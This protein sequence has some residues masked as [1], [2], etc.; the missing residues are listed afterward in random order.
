[1]MTIRTIPAS[2]QH[3]GDLVILTPVLTSRA[4]IGRSRSGFHIRSP[5]G[6]MTI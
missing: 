3:L 6:A 5:G 4:C 2:Q 1:M